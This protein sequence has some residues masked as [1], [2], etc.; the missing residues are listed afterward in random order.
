MDKEMAAELIGTL[1]EIAAEQERLADEQKRTADMLESLMYLEASKEDT[2]VDF[3]NMRGYWVAEP[4]FD[5]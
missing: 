1:E 4:P 3:N 2:N 5:D